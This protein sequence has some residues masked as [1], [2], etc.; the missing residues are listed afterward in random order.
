M[1]TIESGAMRV[2]L[3]SKR[4]IIGLAC[5]SLLLLAG[6]SMVRLAYSQAPTLTYWWADRYFDFNAEQSQQLK[7]ALDGWYDWH[8]RTQMPDY[9]SLLAKGQRDVMGPLTREAMCGWRDDVQRRLDPLVD[10]LAPKLA[11]LALTLTPQ[12]LRRLETRWAKNGDDMKR[13]FAQD[14]REERRKASLERTLERYE[15]FYGRFDDAQRERLSQLLI[16][17]PFDADKWLAERERRN[18]DTISTLNGLITAAKTQDAALAQTQ[19]VAAVKLIASRNLRSPRSEYAAYQERL[20]SENCALAATVHNLMTPAQRQH[21]R[22]KLRG[23]ESDV[24][25]IMA[26]ES[27]KATQGIVDPTML[28]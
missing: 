22:S 14:D 18:R 7:E 5:A 26:S 20:S 3:Q 19:A 2:F 28:R 11:A 4:W 17:S 8:R 9:A 16:T 15:D 23:W 25:A 6:C 1:I 24:R 10:Q 21:A 27:P 13:D 12:Q